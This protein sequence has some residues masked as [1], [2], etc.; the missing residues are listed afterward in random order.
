MKLIDLSIALDNQTKCDQPGGMPQIDYI[1]HKDKMATDSYLGIFQGLQPEDLLDG[2][3]W[4]IE[5]THFSTHNGTHMDA[6][7]HFHS[8][9]NGGEKAWTIDQVP[10]EWCMGHGVV[11]D[12]SDKPTGYCCTSADFIQY[13]AQIGYTLQ[14]NDIVLLHTCARTKWNSNEFWATG[15]GVGREGTLWLIEQGVRCVGTDAWS[16]DV[17]LP[18]QAAEYRKTGDAS[19]IWEGHKAG[20]EKA[21]L[22]IEKLCNLELLPKFGFKFYGFPVKIAGASAGWIRAVAEIDE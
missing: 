5:Q 12:M 13:F 16:W 15:C 1:A 21:Y 14:P 17:P 19:I 8:T 7:Y 10:L 6:P 18:I 2:E 3:A 9:M 20:R 22:Q 4:A 11:V